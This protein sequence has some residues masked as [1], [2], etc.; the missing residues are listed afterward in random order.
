MAGLSATCRHCPV[1]TS[2]GGG[3]YAHRYRSGSGF[4][5]PSVYC[6]D[7]KKIITH[8]RANSAPK[9]QLGQPDLAHFDSLASGYGIR[10]RSRICAHTSE[11]SGAPCCG[12][13]ASMHADGATTRS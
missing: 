2:C 1:V 3:L 6:A 7:L 11:K 10:R 5:N 12:C 8:V 13:C 4:L 9:S